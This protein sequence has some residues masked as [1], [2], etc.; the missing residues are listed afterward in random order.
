MSAAHSHLGSTAAYTFL[1][2]MRHP[3]HRMVF[4]RPTLVD[5]NV[6]T[7]TLEDCGG[8]AQGVRGAH[9]FGHSHLAAARGPAVGLAGPDGCVLGAVSWAQVPALQAAHASFPNADYIVWHDGDAVV[10]PDY[11]DQSLHAYLS[12]IMPLNGRSPEKP[13]MLN[14]EQGN[15]W[16]SQ[17][18]KANASCFNVGLVVLHG[19]AD[20]RV[21][22]VR[23]RR[24]TLASRVY[25]WPSF[26]QECPHRD[27]VRLH[28]FLAQIFL[29]SADLAF[30]TLPA[31]AAPVH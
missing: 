18:L 26:G 24:Q 15:W 4:Y 11:F 29:L 31:G 20:P 25:Q 8:R 5:G 1:Y 7:S 16:C 21:K 17:T 12:L 13:I 9:A 6:A 27:F 30:P 10:S 19:H 22:R 28:S 2:T 14:L 3:E 23:V